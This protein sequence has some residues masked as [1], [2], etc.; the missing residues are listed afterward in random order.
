[1][2]L[3]LGS[4][5]PVQLAKRLR[6]RE[7]AEWWIEFVGGCGLT[8][9]KIEGDPHVEVGNHVHLTPRGQGFATKAAAQAH[10]TARAAGV[11]HL[12]AAIQPE[13]PRSPIRLF[14]RP[15]GGQRAPRNTNQPDQP[16][17]TIPTDD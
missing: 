11:R 5:D 14:T 16:A 6:T 10:E 8:V 9:Q 12:V 4:P 2:A 13:N 3:L 15:G 17:G 7:D 1:M